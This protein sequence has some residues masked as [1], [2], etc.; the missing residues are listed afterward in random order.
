MQI[1][2]NNIQSEF[3]NIKANLTK[4]QIDDFP[5]MSEVI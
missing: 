1:T 5:I 4:Q 2:T 3:A